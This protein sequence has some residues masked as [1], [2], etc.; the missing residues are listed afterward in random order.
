LGH[1][2]E[3][4]RYELIIERQMSLQLKPELLAVDPLTN[5]NGTFAATIRAHGEYM[6]LA[7][8]LRLSP[9]IHRTLS[10]LPQTTIATSKEIGL[11]GAQAFSTYLHETIH[12]WQHIGSTYG[13]MSSLSFI[14]LAHMGTTVI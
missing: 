11:D 8:V 5:G 13:L 3:F 1:H 14:P 2:P 10:S 6:P 4:Y 7:F 9:Q 12:W